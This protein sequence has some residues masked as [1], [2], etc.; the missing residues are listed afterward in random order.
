MKI[1][2]IYATYSGA[3]YFAAQEI[4]QLLESHAHAVTL[5]K[6]EDI[7][8]ADLN[9][10]DFVVFGSCTWNYKGE[11]GQMHPSFH[12]L[13][14]ALGEKKFPNLKCAIFGLGD[15]S[16]ISF[17][18]AVNHLEKLIQKLG[19]KRI[20]P[21]HR[22]NRFYADQEEK[23]ALLKTWTEQIVNAI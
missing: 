18:N 11:E 7:L 22:I 6:P 1:L 23:T 15:S 5:K 16:Y 17:C 8:D 21:S 10:S 2:I 20:V 9:S 13:Q 14:S 3:T 4:Q 19:G 12:Q